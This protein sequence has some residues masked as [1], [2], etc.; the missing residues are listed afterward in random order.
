MFGLFFRKK[1]YIKISICKSFER[2][3]NETV[4]K[5]FISTLLL[6]CFDGTFGPIGLLADCIWG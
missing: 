5:S 3:L 2:C 6:L 1:G 4:Y